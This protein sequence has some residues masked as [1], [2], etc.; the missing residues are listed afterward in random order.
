MTERFGFKM[1]L[2][3][4]NEEKQENLEENEDQLEE[5]AKPDFLDLDKDGDKEES[6]KKAAEDAK[7]KKEMDK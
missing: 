7:E 6:M 1:D 3:K 2:N 4:L 5:E